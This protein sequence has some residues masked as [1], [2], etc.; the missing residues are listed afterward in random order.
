MG[1]ILQAVWD[2]FYGRISKWD[3][4]LEGW[5]DANTVYGNFEVYTGVSMEV[6]N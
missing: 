3:P 2:I 6:S 5:N 1:M 4:V